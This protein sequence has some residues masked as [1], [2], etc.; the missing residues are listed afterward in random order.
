MRRASSFVSRLAAVRRPGSFLEIHVGERL[1][2]LVADD[3]AGVGPLDGPRRREA[4]RH[5][6]SVLNQ[7]SS[8]E[9]EH[10]M[11]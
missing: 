1:P 9:P 11:P 6:K 8:I 2:V 5:A 7:I 10:S 3:E 4:A